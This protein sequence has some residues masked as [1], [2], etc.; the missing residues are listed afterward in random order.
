VQWDREKP[1]HRVK[2]QDEILREYLVHHLYPYSPFYR[3]RFDGA[4]IAPKDIGGLK[5]LAKLEPVSWSDVTA[6]P[7]AFL[8]RPTERAIA[9]FGERKLVMAIARAKLRGR[10]AQVNRELIDPVYKPIHWH[11][12]GEVPIGYSSE[13]LERLGEAGKRLLELA[14][15]G[16][17]DVIA[18]LSAAGPYLGFWQFVDGAREA[19][20]SAVHL[21]PRVSRE[22]LEASAPTVLAGPPQVLEAALRSA[23]AFGRRLAGLRTLLVVS[24]V[25]GDAER[26]SLRALGRSV[27]ESDLEVV[28]AWAPPGMRALWGECRGGRSLHTYPDLECLEV[29]SDGEVAWTSLAWHGTAFLRLRTGVPATIEDGPCPTC[30]RVVPRFV[31]SE[32]QAARSVPAGSVTPGRGR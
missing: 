18:H 6:E 3:R 26:D 8:L 17:D 23:G 30:G 5:D 31:V 2:E 25:L 20:I 7:S 11:L 10:V 12:D 15:V 9:R 22:R 4:K 1:A 13:D 19:G 14:D 16:R 27:G 21:G 28:C 29:L 32:P 24:A